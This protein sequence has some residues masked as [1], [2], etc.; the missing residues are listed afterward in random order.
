MR[1]RDSRRGIMLRWL[2]NSDTCR[3]R[4]DRRVVVYNAPLGSVVAVHCCRCV[5]LLLLLLW[6]GNGVAPSVGRLL[7]KRL[8]VGKMRILMM[9]MMMV[10]VGV[11]C[12][13]PHAESRVLRLVRVHRLL[14]LLWLPS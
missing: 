4:A 8:M 6:E 14:R 1:L 3:H 7:L 10:V 2:H 9:V 11:R 5:L 12:C 13:S